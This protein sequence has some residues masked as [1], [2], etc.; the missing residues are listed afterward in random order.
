M[1]NNNHQIGQ[2]AYYVNGRIPDPLPSMFDLSGKIGE[3]NSYRTLVGAPAVDSVPANFARR[4]FLQAVKTRTETDSASF[5]WI[6]RFFQNR[7]VTTAGFRRDAWKLYGIPAA[8]STIDPEVAGSATQQ[9]RQYFDPATRIVRDGRSTPGVVQKNDGPPLWPE[10]GTWMP[11]A[12]ELPT[13]RA[14]G[15]KNQTAGGKF[16]EQ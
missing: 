16:H 6:G 2:R 8:R 7:L 14:K 15:K 10:P 9:L 4:R 11:E 12:V 13:A 1:T 3:I 5:A